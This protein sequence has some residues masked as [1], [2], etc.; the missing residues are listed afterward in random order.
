MQARSKK[1]P[2]RVRKAVVVGGPILSA[3]SE[4][5][6]QRLMNR[7]L[8]VARRY[9]HGRISYQ[10]LVS[11]TLTDVFSGKRLL[12]PELPLYKNLCRILRSIGSNE[13]QRE[14]HYV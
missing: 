1:T 13:G 5:D 14:K 3:I 9:Y 10:D 8:L 12:D 4:A 11:Q 6:L 7:L 2:E